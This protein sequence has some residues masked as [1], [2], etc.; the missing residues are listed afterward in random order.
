[1]HEDA[2]VVGPATDVALRGN[3]NPAR[4]GHRL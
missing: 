3:M 4:F 1:L 2:T